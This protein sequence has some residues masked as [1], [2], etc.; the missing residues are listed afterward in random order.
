MKKVFPVLLLL[1]F[2]LLSGCSAIQ[3]E[4]AD[5]MEDMMGIEGKSYEEHK[6]QFQKEWDALE[7]DLKDVAGEVADEAKDAAK[8]ILDDTK[9]KA[10][11]ALGDAVDQI[12]INN[13]V[14]WETIMELGKVTLA[15][16]TDEN[17]FTECYNNPFPKGQCTWYAYGRLKERTGIDLDVSGNAKE[18]LDN[19]TDSAVRIERDLTKIR[20]DSIAVF[21]K[22]ADPSHWGH[23]VYVEHVTYDEN[24]VPLMVF[25]SECNMDAYTLKD[26]SKNPKWGVYNANDDC[27]LKLVKYEDF[28]SR[29]G[30]AHQALG[31]IIPKR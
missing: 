15:K 8:E 18:W 3:A 5:Q 14:D 2:L 28:I 12:I 13:S 24:G 20:P 31:Y 1:T 22:P 27:I 29:S 7:D 17:G 25:F 9:E 19:C 30:G 16:I 11:D 4:L 21:H 23:V 10:E 6:E 26:G